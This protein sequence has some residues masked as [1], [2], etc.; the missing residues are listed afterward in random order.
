MHI[1]VHAPDRFGLPFFLFDLD[2]AWQW[3]TTSCLSL[4]TEKVQ[5]TI[6]KFLEIVE[7]KGNP[8]VSSSQSK[9]VSKESIYISGIV[10]SVFSKDITFGV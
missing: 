10:M 5:H 7:Y 4:Q 2:K 1:Q 9:P 6:W 3:N 8:A